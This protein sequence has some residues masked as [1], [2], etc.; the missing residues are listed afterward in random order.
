MREIKF[1]VWDTG[2]NVMWHPKK[3]QD[4]M[5]MENAFVVEKLIW[6]ESTGLKDK[7]G[8]DVYEGDICR[9][10]EVGISSMDDPDPFM[11]IV[12]WDES[13]GGFNHFR[14]DGKEGGSGWS[15]GK[16]AVEKYY[17]VIGNTYENS[18]LIADRAKA[19]N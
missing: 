16:G 9:I 6:L 3:I 19:E 15:F 18:Y 13:R 12:K 4:I 14:I 8:K 7:S 5:E 11:R 1:R 17:E 10:S 2:A